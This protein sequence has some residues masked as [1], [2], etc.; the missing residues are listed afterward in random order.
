SPRDPFRSRK[1][2][3]PRSRT[4]L[5]KGSLASLGMTATLPASRSLQVARDL[6]AP[7]DAGIPVRV[8][9]AVGRH[10]NRV[11]AIETGPVGGRALPP[12]IPAARL[13][14]HPEDP[15]RKLVA[16]EDVER[17]SVGAPDDRK[18]AHGRAGKRPRGPVVDT[19]DHDLSVRADGG[20][21][22][23]VARAGDGVDHESVAQQ[24]AR[25]AP[26]EGLEVP[27]SRRARC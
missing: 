7:L 14:V 13:H 17:A 8:R 19:P 26:P 16:L 3:R 27:T 18:L 24:G 9:A 10:A 15:G 1:T 2:A 5:P 12:E 4:R 21:E 25:L 20:G 11:D 6:E 22:A 23:P